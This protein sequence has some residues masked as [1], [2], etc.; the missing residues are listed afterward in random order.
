[1]YPDRK[2]SRRFSNVD[3]LIGGKTAWCPQKF[4]IVSLVSSKHPQQVP[5]G[6]FER[7]AD[8]GIEISR[9]SVSSLQTNGPGRDE[10]VAERKSRYLRVYLEDKAP[11]TEMRPNSISVTIR[12]DHPAAKRLT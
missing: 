5:D 1:M 2:T 9:S 8:Y 6:G 12:F 10:K 4:R 11:Q 7:S 3:R